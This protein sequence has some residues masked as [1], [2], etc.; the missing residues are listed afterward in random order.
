MAVVSTYA[1][2]VFSDHVGNRFIV[3]PIMFTAVFISS[4]MLLNWDSL[5]NGAHFFAYIIA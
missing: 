1:L 4:V 2:T 5:S 3:N